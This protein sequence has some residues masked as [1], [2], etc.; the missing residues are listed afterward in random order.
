M[1]DPGVAGQKWMAVS[2]SLKFFKVEKKQA[3]WAAEVRLQQDEPAGG[4]KVGRVA[5]VSRLL[6]GTD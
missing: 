5:D 2:S 1:D 4:S 6:S 3:M